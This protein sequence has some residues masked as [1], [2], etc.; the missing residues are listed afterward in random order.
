VKWVAEPATNPRIVHFG[1]FEL[2]LDARELRKSGVRIKL[3]EQPFQI[4]AMLLERPSEIVTREELQRR[5][6]PQDTFVDF[7]LSLN[8]A[9]K[10]LRQ[11]L[12]DDSE[13]PRFV[14]TLYRRGYRFIGPVN[15]AANSDAEL[16]ELVQTPTSAAPL[17][18]VQ[19]QTT[20]PRPIPKRRSLVYGAVALLLILAALVAYRLLPSQPPRVLG[21]T[22]ITHDGLSKLGG[23]SGGRRVIFSD[24]ER[25]YF[26]ELQG[27]HFVVSQVSVAGGETST[28]PTPFANVMIGGITPNGSALV[29]FPFQGTSEGVETWSLPLP[30]GPPR[31]MGDPRA[32]SVAWSP[33]GTQVVFSEGSEIYAAKSDFSDPRK[34]VTA[35]N[36][37]Y[38]LRFSPDGG[39]LRF[40]IVDPRNGSSSIWEI[41]RTGNGLRPLLPGWNSNPRECCGTWTPDGR[42]FLFESSRD[43]RN[44]VWALAEKS[45]WLAG[46]AKPVQLTNG[47]LDFASPMVSKDGKRIF[48]IGS[49]PRCE[50]VRYDG[51]SGFAPYL[52][53]GS[54]SDLAFSGDGKWVA[55][56]SVPEG[57][58]WR[59]RVDG[60]ERLQLTSEGMSAALPRWSPDGREITFMGTNRKT[61]WLAYLIS[62][63][64]T[65]LRELIPGVSA[66]YDPGWSPDGKSIVLTLN[67]AGDPSISIHNEGPGIA[68]YDLETKTISPLPGAGQ[69]FS[70]H[71]SPDGRYI[72]AV[73]NDSLKLMLFD[74]VSQQWQELVSLPIGYPSWSRDG[75]Y[76]Y[77]DT[78]LTGDAAFF[79]VRISDRKLERLLSLKGVRRYW[80]EFGPWTGLAP[81]DSPL[82]ARDTSSQEIYALD[83]QAP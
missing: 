69:L 45:S 32:A 60:S 77:F 8:S 50:L 76:L 28:L 74:R 54:V 36:P 39:R 57:Q 34:L 71:W 68:I 9:V 19:V 47:P 46:T 64:G 13:N 43:G 72:A 56:V 22:Q 21:F 83:W 31:R 23:F 1:L 17:E 26:P 44:S 73:T 24:G 80:G 63:D 15:G 30:S 78:T 11:A 4:L 3:Q 5:L 40:F 53:G 27:D 6:W 20:L 82:V 49:Q 35:E 66:G 38:D 7:D 58:L 48:A 55:Y 79:R 25:L 62:S 10:K 12:G 75:Q 16:M 2:D 33:D 51:K 42:Y 29:V 14:E 59:S 70:P 67:Q 37:V 41:A 18:P 81:D 52:D 61:D 65:G